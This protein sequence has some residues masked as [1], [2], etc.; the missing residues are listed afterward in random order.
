MVDCP[1]A[2]YF[3]RIGHQRAEQFDPVAGA[4]GR[5]ALGALTVDS[6][7]QRGLEKTQSGDDARRGNGIGDAGALAEVDVDQKGPFQSPV[8][9]LHVHFACSFSARRTN[10]SM[11]ELA[12]WLNTGPTI[13]SIKV[14]VNS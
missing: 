11:N 9:D 6:V 8:G 3:L 13:A 2:P 14:V 12:M 4:Y 10:A 1:L 5:V 7:R